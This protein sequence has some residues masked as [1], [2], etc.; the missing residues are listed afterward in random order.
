MSR[1]SLRFRAITKSRRTRRRSPK[2]NSAASRMPEAVRQPGYSPITSL[3]S[4]A[5]C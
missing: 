3:R 1:K 5:N 4:R 2:S